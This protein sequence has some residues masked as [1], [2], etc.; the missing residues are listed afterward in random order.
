M[1]VHVDLT[2]IILKQKSSLVKKIIIFRT[3][4]A[5]RTFK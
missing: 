3:I 2:G 4:K 5:W 1:F